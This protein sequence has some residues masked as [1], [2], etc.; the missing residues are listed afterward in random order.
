MSFSETSLKTPKTPADE[1]IEFFQSSISLGE[2]PI[3]VYELQLDPDGGP[4]KDRAYIRLPPPYRPYVLRVTLDAGT[5]ASKNAVLKT[6]FPLDGGRFARDKFVEKKLPNNFS[7]P[8]HVNLPISHAGAFVYWVEYEGPSSEPIIGRKGYFNIDPVLHVKRR[9]SVLSPSAE[10]LPLSSGGHIQENSVIVPL[11]GL[12][13]LTVVSKWMGTLQKWTDHYREASER[14][15]NMLH[16]TPLQQRGRSG[17]PYSISDQ[18]AFDQQLVGNIPEEDGVVSVKE[19]LRLAREDFGLLSLTDVVL[20]HTADNSPWLLDH[21]EAGFSPLNTPHLVPALELDT[22]IIEF[23]STL[24]SKGLPTNISS[25]SELDIILNALTLKVK[26]ELKLWEFYVLDRERE[27]KGILDI[28]NQDVP[29]WTGLDVKGKPLGELA[30]ILKTAGKI[31]GLKQYRARYGVH[32]DSQDAASFVRAAFTELKDSASLAD[33]WLKVVDVINSPLYDEWQED[34]RVALNNVKNRVTYTRL[35]AHG[36]RLGEITAEQ[37]LVETYFTRLPHNERTSKHNPDALSLANNGWIWNADPLQNFALLPSKAY[38]RR[39]VIVW[40][41]CVKLRYGS[42]PAD[43]PWLWDYMTRYVTTLAGVFDGFRIDNCHSTPLHVGVAL[44]D[45][46]R[47]V[48]PNLYV[49]AELFTGNEEMD[50]RFV[51]HLGINSLIREAYNGYDPKELSRLLYRF[52]VSNPIGSMDTACLT[53]PEDLPPPTG[54]GPTRPCLVTPL[55]GSSPHALL[56]DVTHDNESPLHKR[57]AEDAL[58]TGALVAFSGSAV[59]SN[60]GFDDLYPKLLDLVSDNRQYEVSSRGEEKGIS[61]VKRVLNHL[62]TEMVLEGFS[63][64]HVHQENDY[65]AIHRVHPRTGKGYLLIA[66]TAFSK[67]SKSRGW[68]NPTKLARTNAKFILGASINIPSY[69]LEPDDKIIRGLSSHLIELATVTPSQGS[70]ADGPYSEITVPEFFPPGSVLLFVTQ[71]HGVDTDL[72]EFCKSE[73]DAAM[74]NLNLVDLNVILHRADSEERD[75]THGDIGTYEIPGHS[76]LVYAG[77]EGWMALLRSIIRYNDLGHAL[78]SH[79]RSG[80]WA[81][82]YIYYRLQ[83]QIKDLPN[84][85]CPAKWFKER[86]DRIESTVPSF[87]RPKY[88]ALVIYEAYK[89]ARRAVIEQQTEFISSGHSF[90]QDLALC[91]VQMH[92][93]VQTASIDPAKAIP[94]LAAGLPHFTTGWARCWGRDVFISLRGLFLTTGNFLAAKHHILAFASTLKHGLIPNLLDSVRNPRYNSR[95]SPWWMLQ[96]IQDYVQFAPDGIDILSETVKRRFPRDDAF[97]S[98]DDP[99]AYAYSSTI[100]EVI[101]E[102][103]QR[104]ANGISFREHNAGPN[105]D[106]QMVD[107]G[108]NIKI[109]VDWKTGLV[110][111]GNRYN[112][113]TWMDKMGESVKAGTKG[114]PGTPRD[115]APIEITGLLK[116][117]LRWLNNLS[118][119]GSFPFKGVQTNINDQYRLVTYKEWNDLI[120]SAFERNYYIPHDPAEDINYVVHSAL[121][122]RRGIY[123]DVFGSGQDHEWADYQLRPNFPIAMAVAPEL[124]HP[125]HALTALKI[126]DKVLRS[127]LGMKT[128]DP[129]DLQYRGD[130]DNSNDS[131]DPS[132]AKG[133]NYHNGPEWGWP[134]GYFLRAYLHFD[135]QVESGRLGH[136]ETLHSLH[137]MLRGLRDHMQNDPWRGLPELTNRDGSYCRDSCATQAWSSSTILDFLHDVHNISTQSSSVNSVSVSSFLR[138]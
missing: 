62:H 63:E 36:P 22:A 68:F 126:V 7:K 91:S 75:A 57:S 23:S 53:I 85:A 70:N 118:T 102:I 72:D 119:K 71:L 47:V 5:P 65:I 129:S 94:S 95:D 50:T 38:L 137:S 16:Y 105:L 87:L 8:I 17:S 131:N 6:N 80:T 132:I 79:L 81:L 19:A 33:A 41:D 15:Y 30:E 99:K 108:F 58:S 59:G 86:F 32:V 3:Y 20:N 74:K 89:A 123:K 101:Q 92:G 60:K 64:G 39:E 90:I 111:G 116:S 4:N 11:D 76:T 121:V 122:N 78:C 9:S 115:G 84:L 66:H 18:L 48:N 54:K 106:M 97:V 43:N 93:L 27:R 42:C 77:L 13:I 45:A 138:E 21:P 69:D 98:W 128:L 124:F 83:K 67:G 2:A 10:P 24:A 26:D 88:F 103:L 104:H 125:Q 127:P 112:C 114:T 51:S 37:P 130:Y 55:R 133:L 31:V 35:D 110:F 34:I 134:L 113:G 100:A 28:L 29:V 1:G 107:E 109:Y 12:V 52:G 46:A 49:C 73:A 82:E 136:T 40:G 96:N 44:L 14:G 56:F 135:I 25:Q 120:Q 61:K 117:T